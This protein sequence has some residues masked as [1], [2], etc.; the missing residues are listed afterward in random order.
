MGRILQVEARFEF[1][2]TGGELFKKLIVGAILSTITFGIYLP[3]YFVALQKYI[4][5]NTSIKRPGKGDI[6]LEFTGTGG[7]LFK[8]GFVGYLLTMIT[9]GIYGFWFMAKLNKYFLSNS[10]GRA[11]DGEFRLDS[12]LEG[13]ELFGNLF[14]GALLTGITFGIYYPWF[15]CKL[16][17]IYF[18]KLKILHNNQVIGSGDFVGQGGELFGLLFV[19]ALLTAVTFYIYLA[20]ANVNI[21]KFML[22]K[23]EL[24]IRGTVYRG[25][26]SGTGGELFVINLVGM[27][28]TMVTFGIYSFWFMCK[29]LKFQLENTRYR[30]AQAA[31]LSPGVARVAMAPRAAAGAQ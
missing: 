24:K 26:F 9:F 27:L 31:E 6:A 29:Q 5:E 15:I 3:W 10:R 11:N 14:V 20:W 25:D 7:E 1:R 8:I 16:Q 12:D 21:L 23:T 2:G 18:N 28:L 17:K 19:N 4:Y 22:S 30:S 13:G